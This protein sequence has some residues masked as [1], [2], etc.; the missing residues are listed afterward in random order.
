MGQVTEQAAATTAILTCT[1]RETQQFCI[2]R[3]WTLAFQLCCLVVMET[4]L[5]QPLL[6]E[7]SVSPSRSTAKDNLMKFS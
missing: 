1:D 4:D 6:A 2:T 3:A 5:F 7:L